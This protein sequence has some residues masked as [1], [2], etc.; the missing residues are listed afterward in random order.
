LRWTC[1][2]TR[3]LAEVLSRDGHRVSYQTVALLLHDLG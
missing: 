2:S 1:K 3:H